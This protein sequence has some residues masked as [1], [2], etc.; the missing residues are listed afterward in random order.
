[1]NPKIAPEESYFIF[2]KMVKQNMPAFYYT[3][4]KDIFLNYYEKNSKFQKI[5]PLLNNRFR[6]TSN[7]LE[8]Y[9]TLFLRLKAVISG[10]EFYSRE[11]IFF[12]ILKENIT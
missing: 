11:N 7:F 6:I 2:R 9:L 12:N 5:I 8:K 1:M 3:G 10:A 4:R